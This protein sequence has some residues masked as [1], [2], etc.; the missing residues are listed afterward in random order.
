MVTL[1]GFGAHRYRLSP[2]RRLKFLATTSSFHHFTILPKDERQAELT[3]SGMYSLGGTMQSAEGGRRAWG[4][5]AILWF[6]L[7]LHVRRDCT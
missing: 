3:I 7:W 1:E 5:F 4:A 2:G 6:C